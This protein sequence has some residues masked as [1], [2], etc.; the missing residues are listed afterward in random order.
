MGRRRVPDWDC[1]GKLR[2]P[3]RFPV[4]TRCSFVG[5]CGSGDDGKVSVVVGYGRVV[6]RYSVSSRRFDLFCGGG[7]EKATIAGC[8]GQ[9]Q[10]RTIAKGD[11][12]ALACE[13]GGEVRCSILE[14][15]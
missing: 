7:L 12:H 3:V 15:V 2:C 5:Q 14:N 4:S 1:F 8:V 13:R 9:L 10:N 6:N 11:W